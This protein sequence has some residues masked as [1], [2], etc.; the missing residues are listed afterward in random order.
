[1]KTNPT[2]ATPSLAD[3]T[4]L[5]RRK[6]IGRE[7]A[8]LNDLEASW[9]HY[10]YLI[11]KITPAATPSS[12]VTRQPAAQANLTNAPEPRPP[13]TL[14]ASPCQIME[15]PMPKLAL[16]LHNDKNGHGRRESDLALARQ[17]ARFAD[18]AARH[19]AMR[20][21]EENLETEI[22]ALEADAKQEIVDGR[23]RLSRLSAR[24]ADLK[25]RLAKFEPSTKR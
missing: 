3:L 14:L 2:T 10:G 17:G 24:L 23:E 11:R 22:A 1:M 15:T 25:R 4:P 12:L 8:A 6:K 9:R 7:A 21:T 19:A 16:T 5:E 18:S 20:D 13:G